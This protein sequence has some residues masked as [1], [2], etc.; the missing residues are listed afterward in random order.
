MVNGLVIT[1]VAEF[2]LENFIIMEKKKAKK[3]GIMKMVM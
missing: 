1:R 3:F 2:M